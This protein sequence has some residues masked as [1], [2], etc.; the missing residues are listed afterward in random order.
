MHSLNPH[1]FAET[2]SLALTFPT[3]AL[4][5]YVLILWGPPAFDVIKKLIA[6]PDTVSPTDWFVL[7]V[8]VGFQGSILDN[9]Y[10]FVAWSVDFVNGAP[11]EGLIAAGVYFNI[12]SRQM[13][14][15]LAAYCHVRSAVATEG[16]GVKLQTLHSVLIWSTVAGLVYIHLLLTL[17]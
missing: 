7:G 1:A 16:R 6:S 10:W 9:L 15:M 17:R 8:A 13:A 12:P 5:I 4:A 3:V 2:T 14:G 11:S